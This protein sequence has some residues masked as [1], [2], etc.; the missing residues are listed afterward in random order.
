VFYPQNKVRF[1][2]EIVAINTQPTQGWSVSQARDA[3][4]K[5]DPLR[6]TLDVRPSHY[7]QRL[8]LRKGGEPRLEKV[9]I[10]SF[11]MSAE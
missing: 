8:V 1:G 6:V 9:C 3:I 11:C 10:G 2:D 4:A 5:T 7:I